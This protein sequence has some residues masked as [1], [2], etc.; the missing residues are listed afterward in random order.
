[1]GYVRKKLFKHANL[2]TGFIIN[3]CV[4]FNIIKEGPV[5]DKLYSCLG[6]CT[7]TWPDCHVVYIGYNGRGKNE[8]GIENA[9]ILFVVVFL[10][11]AVRMTNIPN[12]HF[13][14][15]LDNIMTVLQ[16]Y[17]NKPRVILHFS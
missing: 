15:T 10:N 5:S 17:S 7:L 3:N 11:P 14:R 12:G 13:I 6:V 9:Y 2:K 16:I 4:E 1:M 8:L